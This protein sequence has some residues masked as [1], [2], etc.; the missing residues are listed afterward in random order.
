MENASQYEDGTWIKITGEISEGYYY[1][2]IPIINITDIEECDVP[3]EKEVN[4]PSDNY[5]PTSVIY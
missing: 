5:V 3:E 4:P 1:D 2:T